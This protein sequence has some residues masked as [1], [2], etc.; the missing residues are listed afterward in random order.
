MDRSIE[1]EDFTLPVR[2]TEREVTL[3]DRDFSII[4][5]SLRGSEDSFSQAAEEAR[6][7]RDWDQ[8][9]ESERELSYIRD[10]LGR[11]MEVYRAP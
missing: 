10:L 1:D 3:T 4:L 6:H 5:A 8:V 9:E 2:R 7:D 11:L